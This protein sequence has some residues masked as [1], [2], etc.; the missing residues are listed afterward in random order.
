MPDG[1]P[2]HAPGTSRPPVF[3]T[4]TTRKSKPRCLKEVNRMSNV[5]KLQKLATATPTLSVVALSI[6]SCDSQS[7]NG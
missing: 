1:F 3:L 7:C 5:L 4:G 6:S 2:A